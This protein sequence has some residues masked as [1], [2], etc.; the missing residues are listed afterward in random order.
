MHRFPRLPTLMKIYEKATLKTSLTDR[1]AKDQIGSPPESHVQPLKVRRK[2]S[3]LLRIADL[4]QKLTDLLLKVTRDLP[5]KAA[6]S[7]L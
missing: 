7:K 1:R 3:Q 4:S 6:R 5:E 2:D